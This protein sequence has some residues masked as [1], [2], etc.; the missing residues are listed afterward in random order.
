M[1]THIRFENV[2]VTYGP[3]TALDDISLDIPQKQILAVIGPAN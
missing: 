2:T 3:K 1:P